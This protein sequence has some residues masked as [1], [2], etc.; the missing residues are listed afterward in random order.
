MKRLFAIALAVVMILAVTVSVSAKDSPTGKVYYS[1]TTSTELPDGSLGTA[2]SDKDK[3]DKTADGDDSL[4][5]LTASQ[6]NGFFTRW[7]IQGEYDI[8]SGDIESPVLVIRPKSDV[9]ATASFTVDKDSLTMTVSVVGDGTADANPVKVAKGS[10]GTVTFT[11]VDGK[12]TFTEWIFDGGEYEIIE[13]DLKS[14]KLVV[15]P[16]TDLY[17]TA[18][19]GSSSAPAS[20]SASSGNTG[21]TSPKTGDPLFIVLGLAVLALGAG[22]LAIKK[23]KE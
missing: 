8:I 6:T 10:D 13:G 2:S 1:I 3:V 23:I 20:S 4:V 7:I 19:F 9:H 18:V 15:K 21:S 22:A 14:R 16:F 5:T 17:A 12:D 11:A